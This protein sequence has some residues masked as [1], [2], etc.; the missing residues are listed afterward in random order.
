MFPFN[1]KL[2]EL[3][4]ISEP[5]QKRFKFRVN[6]SIFK[7]NLET[8][9]IKSRRYFCAIKSRQKIEIFVSKMFP[10]NSKLM[11][12]KPISKPTQ[13]RFKF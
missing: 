12:L 8:F 11:E 10:I 13:K 5:T 9:S 1:S 4:P 7:A 2:M 6:S 3:K